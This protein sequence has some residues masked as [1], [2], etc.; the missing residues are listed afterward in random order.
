MQ[1]AISSPVGPRARHSTASTSEEHS[2]MEA[3]ANVVNYTSFSSQAC[4]DVFQYSITS[5]LK[6]TF[7]KYQYLSTCSKPSLPR[8]QHAGKFNMAV[9]LSLSH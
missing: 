9:T 3:N 4:R 1:P 8:L 7:L 6:F 2:V 5:K